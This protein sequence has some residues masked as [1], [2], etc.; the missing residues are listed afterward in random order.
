MGDTKTLRELK[1]KEKGIVAK[2]R[3]RGSIRRRLMDMG[4]VKGAEMEVVRVAPL[5]DPIDVKVKG[6]HL[7]M[8]KADADDIL[9]EVE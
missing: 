3:G 7:S 5:G 1:V 4:V 8:R 6:Y 9:L 2:M